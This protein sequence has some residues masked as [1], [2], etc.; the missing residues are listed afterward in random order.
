MY[1]D[2]KLMDLSDLKYMHIEPCGD[3][4][5]EEDEQIEKAHLHDG[6]GDVV[7]VHRINALWQDLFKNI[8]VSI[9][10]SVEAYR[11]GEKTTDLL[12]Q[13]IQAYESVVFF[14]GNTTNIEKKLENRVERVHMEEVETSSENCGTGDD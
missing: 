14:I 5:H 7:H 4:D 2:D 1:V 10:A 3:D 11:N 12:N 13:P 8:D 9:P 6:V